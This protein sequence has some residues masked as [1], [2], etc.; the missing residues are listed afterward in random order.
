MIIESNLAIICNSVFATLSSNKQEAREAA[1]RCTSMLLDGTDI[2][3]IM[4]YLCHGILYALPRSR[5][6]LLQKL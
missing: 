3:I 1:E 2:Q 5:I 6:Y 4:Q